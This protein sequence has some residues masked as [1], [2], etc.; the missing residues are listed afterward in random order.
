[1]SKLDLSGPAEALS[2]A[3]RRPLAGFALAVSLVIACQAPAVNTGPTAPAATPGTTASSSAG[4][5][6]AAG[7][8]GW[9]RIADI[10]TP[11]SEVA[12]SEGHQSW[13]FFVVGG[14]G[15]RER[16]ESYDDSTGR[17]E[18]MPDL[19]IGVDHPMA[20][21]VKGLQSNAPQ[22]VFVFGGY[23][24]NATA[25]SF[26]FDLGTGRWNEIAP[27]P[28]PRA[29]GAA[30]ALG[31]RI[32]VVGGADGSRLIAPTYEYNVTTQQWRTVA[33]IPTPRDHLAAVPLAGKVCAVGG[34]RLSM[35]VNLGT[36]ECYDPQTDSWTRLPDAPT[37]RGGVG[38]AVYDQRVYFVGGEQPSG[39]F[40]EVEVFDTRT[41]S[42]TR[43]PDLPTA[44]HGLAV[45]VST[46]SK[47]ID[48]ARNLVTTPPRLLVLTGGPTP[49]GS[50]TAVCE[51]LDLP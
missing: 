27:M 28:G 51:A 4:A 25:R 47:A 29:A 11:R 33:A 2:R 8:S 40:R 16:V 7:T 41:N 43:G 5:S 14:F 22:G 48:A 6:P 38:A 13:T 31:D 17:W 18:R 42:W 30:V 49:G 34:R 35:S 37:A 46:G 24:G 32:F 10:P 1:V 15:G 39:T 12:A 45:V 26:R 23:S 19:P 20:A 21:T 50:Q 3:T 36:F 44:R 9:R